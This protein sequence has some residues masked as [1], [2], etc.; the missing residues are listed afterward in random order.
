MGFTMSRRARQ[1]QQTAEEIVDAAE[2]LVISADP[3]ALSAHGIARAL[4]VTPGA[5]YR[6]FPG[7]DAIVARVQARVV[8]SLFAR[9]DA[10]VGAVPAE[11]PLARLIAAT[12]AVLAFAAAEPG[13]YALLAKML[14]EPR[15]LVGDD[16]VQAVL[17]VA[18]G[19]LRG[20]R[21]L[22]EAARAP[23]G[24]GA[25][26]DVGRLLALWAAVHGATQL[27]KLGRFAPEASGVR[28]GRQA[29][30]ALLVGWGASPAAVAAA[31]EVLCR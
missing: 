2:A 15:P 14:A 1:R 21:G 26:D 4:G 19:G 10:G 16:A 3:G 6:Y 30:D 22:L 27:D 23:G 13:R 12:E 7:I 17:P 29:V 31:R 11:Q 9:I 18:L 24:L 25:G 8:G 20:L 5:L 28:I